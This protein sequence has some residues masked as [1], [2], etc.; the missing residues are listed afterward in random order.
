MKPS[1]RTELLVIAAAVALLLAQG[2]STIVLMRQAH[3]AA[4]AAASESVHRVARAVEASVNRNFVQV[5]AMLAGLPAVLGQLAG[6]GRAAGAGRPADLSRVLRDLNNQNFAW[7]DVILV[8]EDGLPVASALPV[9]RRRPLP[10]S[11]DAA[12]LEGTQRPGA[13]RIAGPV[14]NPATGEWTLFL[15]RRITLP[16]FG[17]LLAAAEVPVPGLQTLL[18]SAGGEAPG[19]RVTLERE[20]GTLLASLPHDETRIARRLVPSAPEVL[21]PADAA[22]VAP[23]R[24]PTPA[25]AQPIDPAA[26]ALRPD[27]APRAEAGLARLP[28][29]FD[30]AGVF[31][32]VRPTLYPAV[33]VGASLRED[34]ALADWRGDVQRASIAAGGFA[35]LVT[36]LA[37]AV[38]IGLRQR[39]RA[40]AE[41]LRWR[42]MLENAL[43][44]MEGGFVIWD[45]DD[46]LVACNKRYRAFYTLSAPF[47]VTGALFEDVMR[48]GALAGQYPQAGQDIEAFV[49]D[50]KAWH[51]GNHTPME[52]LLPDGR[53]V[54]ITESTIPD[55]GVVGVRTDI[56]ALKAA[57]TGIAEAAEAKARFLARMSHELRTP[58]NGI[59]G[60][61]QIL[62]SGPNLGAEQRR[63]IGTMEAAGRHLLELVNGLLDLSKIDAGKLRLATHPTGLRPLLEGCAALLSPELERKNQTFR[64]DIGSALP[65]AVLADATR[66]RQLL[67]NLLANA[68]K[69]TPEGGHI[70]LRAAPR[71]SAIRFE[72]QDTGPGVPAD[73]RHLLFSDFV[74]L[75]DRNTDATGTGLGLSISA[76]LATLM[77]GR[78]GCGDA[79]GGGALFWVELPM[80]AASMAELAPERG[81]ESGSKSGS[82][83]GHGS[84]P[85]PDEPGGTRRGHILVVDD[86]SA[87]RLVAQSMLQA[88]GHRVACAADGAEALALVKSDAFDLVL[89]DLQMP[90][91]DG[92]E[93]TRRIRA[94][95]S[96]RNAIPVLAV[97]ASALPEQV[98]ACREAGMDGHL[99]KPVDREGLLSEVARLLDQR[100]SRALP[101]NEPMLM[102]ETVLIMLAADLGASGASIIAEFVAELR[103]VT[104]LLRT[105]PDPEALRGLA[106]RMVGAARTLGARR[107]A[108]AAERL[109]AAE[110]NGGETSTLVA[111]VIEAAAASLPVL[112]AWVQ[113]RAGGDPWP[114][115]IRPAVAFE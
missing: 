20:D 40:E 7:R 82:D 3:D 16:G 59:L 54:L 34:M 66:V 73:L 18:A 87:N 35:L 5:D 96:P 36:A 111:R 29:R 53:W 46:R 93:A 13:M 61:A 14:R 95:P 51:R 17:P 91:M 8:G 56:T 32:A 92:L 31:L 115:T 102:D 76:R 62:L 55:G 74:Q 33:L 27:A 60:F 22:Q 45:K 43:E 114:S 23:S 19:F 48:G 98:A 11:I 94:L 85:S 90:V 84:M 103:E 72:V 21:R 101:G 24:D 49:A 42:S 77:G 47:I 65:A 86:L 9:S 88:A 105:G 58:L 57:M 26:T 71:S 38:L 112:E 68:V 99:A 41:G 6:D 80:P 50:M 30:G 10:L 64:L 106:H 39:D 100:S 78:I 109:Q 69:F 63:Q 113:A 81:G 1:R 97:T 104:G 4:V 2:I 107:L 79:P 110:R 28:G 108:L 37:L 70:I 75:A 12:F 89:M 67:L 44:G 25:A 83:S 52:R 15:V